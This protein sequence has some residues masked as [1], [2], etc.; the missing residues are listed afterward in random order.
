MVISPS[1]SRFGGRASR[2][3][4]CS[5]RSWSSA[6]SSIVTMRSSLGMNDESTLR[7]VVLPEP[8]PPET[9]RFSRASMQAWRNSN[10]SGVA[11]PNR[12]RSSTVYGVCAN[13]RTV[14]TGPDQ[15]QGLDDGVDARAIRKARVDAWARFVDA[16]AERGDDPLDDA[17][18]V[19]VVEEQRVDPLDLALAL[20]VDVVRAV[21]HDLG[22]GRVRQERFQRPEAGH[23]VDHLVDEAHALLAGDREAA[24]LDDP[25]DHRFDGLSDV[26]I[27]GIEQ[28]LEGADDFDLQEE[29]DLVDQGLARRC[30]GTPQGARAGGRS[31]TGHRDDGDA[32]RL[33]GDDRGRGRRHH[34]RA[35]P[36]HRGPVG[37]GDGWRVDGRRGARRR[38]RAVQHVRRRAVQRGQRGARRRRADHA[39]VCRAVLVGRHR[40]RRRRSSIHRRAIGRRG[41]RVGCLGGFCLRRGALGPLDP[42]QSFDQGH[43]PHLVARSYPQDSP[44]VPDSG[45]GDAPPG[46]FRRFH[47]ART[48]GPGPRRPIRRHAPRLA[49]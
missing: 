46:G 28:D 16:P 9:N 15:G 26:A 30:P 36:S 42:F 32:G 47:A 25:V 49:G 33:R 11:V 17:Q 43:R 23:V 8:V 22:D 24:V 27:L 40:G 4:T 48:H 12:I 1:P 14:M 39:R 38:R 34:R 19:L 13:L 5:W 18:H 44:F 45:C 31:R 37:R 21:D 2:V 3:T 6:A 20:D 7:V 41:A 29:P 35:G 10:I